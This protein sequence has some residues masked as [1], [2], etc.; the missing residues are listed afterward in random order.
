MHTYIFG[1]RITIL[2]VLFPHKYCNNQSQYNIWF[3]ATLYCTP[4]MCWQACLC[5]P[6]ENKEMEIFAATQIPNVLQS[7]VASTLNLPSTNINVRVKRLGKVMSSL[8][9]AAL[10]TANQGISHPHLSKNTNYLILDVILYTCKEFSRISF[11]II[12]NRNMYTLSL[13][14]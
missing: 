3:E 10:S 1:G 5:I 7:K 9:T 12:S 11:S 6:Q 8:V 4:M 13:P 14:W 2:L